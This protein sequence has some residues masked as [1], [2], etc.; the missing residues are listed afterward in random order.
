MNNGVVCQWLRKSKEFW[1]NKEYIQWPSAGL[2]P[3]V[4]IFKSTFNPSATHV[5]F[6]NILRNEQPWQAGGYFVLE[7]VYR[8]VDIGAVGD[9]SHLSL[10]NMLGV[11]NLIPLTL[12]PQEINKKR[13][14][15][16]NNV[17]SYL[18]LYSIPLEK[19]VATYF[20][21][22]SVFE[23]K[24]DPDTES[25]RAF[26][27]VGFN[28]E[29]IIGMEG[30]FAFLYSPRADIDLA[31][32]RNDLYFKCSDST[33]IEIATLDFSEYVSVKSK[34][35]KNPKFIMFGFYCGIER[36]IAT[37]FGCDIW[38]I[39]SF[40]ALIEQTLKI[41][42]IK[43][44]YN[45]GVYE[46]QIMSREIKVFIDRLRSISHIISNNQKPD[47]SDRGQMLK[48]LLKDTVR[49]CQNF[50]GRLDDEIIVQTLK[51]IFEMDE[52]DPLLINDIYETI[53]SVDR[54]N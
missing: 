17:L 3:E 54:K 18:N 31:G 50:I 13:I 24:F 33:V 14:E 35:E 12:S 42:S 2:C 37:S 45:C 32:Y 11:V 19:L 41:L 52:L 44:G 53:I 48:R 21:G 9:I 34:I 15:F 47:N 1:R 49:F 5:Q 23:N 46:L 10:F 39:D 29:N 22:G 30:T 20:H 25:K 40:K 7:K 4:P 36:L 6:Y 26:N 16:L 38:E 28:D 43:Y 27:S 8:H 51:G